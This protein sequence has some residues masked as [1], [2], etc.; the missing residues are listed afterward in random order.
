[1]QRIICLN[2][3][4]SRSLIGWLST[5]MQINFLIRKSYNCQKYV[6]RVL[7]KKQTVYVC[8]YAYYFLNIQLQRWKFCQLSKKL[9][10]RAYQ[11]ALCFEQYNISYTKKKEIAKFIRYNIPDKLFWGVKG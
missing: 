1:M 3:K 10:S 4:E 8:R 7:W 11:A 9:F 2:N 5:A 6:D